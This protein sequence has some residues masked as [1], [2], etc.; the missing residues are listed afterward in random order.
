MSA[1]RRLARGLGWTTG[2]GAGRAAVLI[3]AV[4]L[5]G[6]VLA[7]TVAGDPGPGLVAA[8]GA[9]VVTARDGAR[10]RT[11]ALVA[12]ATGVA[13]WIA[14]ALAAGHGA[15]TH[16]VI[17]GLTAAAAAGAG[18]DRRR[19][20]IAVRFVLALLITVNLAESRPLGPAS[21]ALL[22]AG[23][24][25][26]LL[27]EA[28]VAR[29]APAGWQPASG[30]A[31]DPP[32]GGRGRPRVPW[33]LLL[34]ACVAVAEGLAWLWPGHHAQWIALTVAL[35]MRP[36]RDA[37]A[38]RSLQRGLGTLLGVIAA[39]ALLP[40]HPSSWSLVAVMAV[41]GAV[42]PVARARSY[43]VYTA[44]MTPLIL[45]MTGAGRDATAGVLLDRVL[46]TLAGIA[47]VLA[48]T[49]L[50]MAASR[51]LAKAAS[52]RVAKA[53]SRRRRS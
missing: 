36:G 1:R 27:V 3:S 12:L 24:L 15:W 20:A 53:A 44:V 46:A 41:L 11:E 47:I 13:A 19:L 40:W 4:G 30:A 37:A 33:P 8:A 50:A 42:R 43:L 23:G 35:L 34:A 10:R 16:V 14:G 17:A 6:P 51:R 7:A 22:A 29:L 18:G 25:W 21:V 52:R 26:A 2:P 45:L 9:L 49:G 28:V 39:G 38:A 5:A 31:G 32:G 48:A